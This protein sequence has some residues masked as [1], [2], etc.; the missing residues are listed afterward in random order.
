MCL[1]RRVR[2]WNSTAEERAAAWPCDEL[3]PDPDL[4]VFRAV[5]VA[6][7]PEMV[8]RWLCQLRVAPYS[9]DWIDNLGRRS[10]RQLTP[11]L[12]QLEVG[13]RVATIFELVAFEPN[14]NVTLR[15]CRS[16]FGDVA[17]TYRVVPDRRG[18]SRLAV[19]LLVR[20]RRDPLGRVWALVLPAGDLVMMHKQLRTLA[21]LAERDSRIAA[22]EHR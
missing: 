11:G 20:H 18:G 10:P 7:S 4:V 8:F 12:D 6:A 1:G 17:G 13:Q 22:S 2:E 15:S 14:V 3:L 5:D 16:L 19:K 9:Y 21:R